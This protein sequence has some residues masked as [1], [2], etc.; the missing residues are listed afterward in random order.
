V[1][2]IVVDEFALLREN[3]QEA[4]LPWRDPVVS[5]VEQRVG[6]RAVSAIVWGPA[7]PRLVL[8]HGGGQNTP[9][10][11]AE[12]VAPVLEVPGTDVLVVPGSGHSVQSDQPRAMA[13]I[14]GDALG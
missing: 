2:D 11:H 9:A 13:D 14:I 6:E 1:I 8:L 5:R 7:P 12:A 3:A 4:G 10:T